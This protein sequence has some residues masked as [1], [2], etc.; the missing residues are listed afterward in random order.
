ME[1]SV[2]DTGVGIPDENMDK[3]FTPLFSTKV[4]GVGFGL[5]IVKRLVEAHGGAIAVESKMGEGTTFTFTL[6]IK[7][8]E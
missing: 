1:V 5:Y 7:G 2:A 3:L 6:P 8:E 4:K